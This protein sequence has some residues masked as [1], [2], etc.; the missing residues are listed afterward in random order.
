MSEMREQFEKWWQ[1]TVGSNMETYAEDKESHWLAWQAATERAGR[2]VCEDCG[3][4]YGPASCKCQEHTPQPPAPAVPEG[5]KLV[6]VEPTERMVNAYLQAQ[7]ESVEGTQ[8]FM[9]LSDPPTNNKAGYRAMLNATP[10]P[11]APAVPESVSN[12]WAERLADLC[13]IS[14]SHA[15]ETIETVLNAAPQPTGGES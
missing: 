10:Q 2:G 7:R 11:T 3:Y 1:D 15:R 6:P 14:V 13:E 8:D 9:G 12:E 4:E 5:W